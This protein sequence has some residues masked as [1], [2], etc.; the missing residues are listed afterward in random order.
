MVR[1]HNDGLNQLL[2]QDTTL[3]HPLGLPDG[4]NIRTSKDKSDLFKPLRQPVPARPISS[5]WSS[6]AR[7]PSSCLQA[8]E[9]LPF[10]GRPVD[11]YK[12]CF[13][14]VRDDATALGPYLRKKRERAGLTQQD[15]ADK[16]G[17]TQPAISYLERG[18]YPPNVATLQRIAEALGYELEVRM[19]SFREAIDHGQPFR[20]G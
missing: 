15:L 17:C 5:A 2:D 16:L 13:M 6:S 3:G 7:S 9:V 20:F 14:R 4:C 10:A 8:Q 12:V 1:E 19:V 18:E 11:E